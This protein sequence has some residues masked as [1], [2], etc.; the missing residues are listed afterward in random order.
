MG[1]GKSKIV[2]AALVNRTLFE[3]KVKENSIGGYWLQCK[4]KWQLPSLKWECQTEW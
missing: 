1:N 4:F 2:L 3:G